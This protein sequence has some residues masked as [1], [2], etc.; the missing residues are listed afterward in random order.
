MGRPWPPILR[1]QQNVLATFHRD[2][3]CLDGLRT[4]DEQRNHHV[5]E[6]H[7]VAQ[8][9]QRIAQRFVAIVVQGSIQT[10][11]TFASFAQ[12]ARA[13]EAIYGCRS[14]NLALFAVNP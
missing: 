4:P 6:Y 12:T 5:R 11:R 14:G 1:D 8:R 2:F 9:Q 7:H 10:W 3:K 13:E